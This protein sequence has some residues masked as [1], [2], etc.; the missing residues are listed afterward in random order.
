MTLGQVTADQDLIKKTKIYPKKQA[1]KQEI[2]TFSI[3]ERME[4]RRRRLA[5]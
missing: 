3:G 2:T 5:P 1:C 4:G